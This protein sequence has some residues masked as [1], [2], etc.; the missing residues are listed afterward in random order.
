MKCLACAHHIFSWAGSELV[1]L[2]LVEGL[3]ARGHDV[4]LFCS[5]LDIS[6][7][8]DT[9]GPEVT[10]LFDPAHVDLSQ[11][12]LVF[13]SH[14][15]P[16]RFL[17]FQSDDVL[18]GSARP[19]VVYNHMSPS[20]LFERPGPVS[21]E[22][23]ADLILC[24]S[25]ETKD[26]LS[27]LSPRMAEAEI[28]PN[29]APPG[30]ERAR[31]QQLKSR[32]E[33]LLCVSNHLPEEVEK[34]LHLLRDQGV[35]I[36]K[37]G[38]PNNPKRLTPEILTEHDAVLTIGKT[39]QYA[40]RARVP[41]FC[42]DRY[43]GPGWLTAEN[44]D[45]AA[46]Y[47]FSGRS[48]SLSRLPDALAQKIIQGFADA[49]LF[50][51]KMD[52]TRLS[53]YRLEDHLTR[54]ESA[55]SKHKTQSRKIPKEQMRRLRSEL[56]REYD[57][58]RLVDQEYASAQLKERQ[59]TGVSE[60]ICAKGDDPITISRLHSKEN[61]T[62]CIVATFAYR[63]DAHLVPAMLEN[64]APAVDA[65]I[66]W[67]DRKTAATFSGDAKRQSA[68]FEA[69]KSIGA[70]WILAIDPDERY[71]DALAQKIKGFVTQEPAC[72]IFQCREMFTPTKFRSDGLWGNKK[73]VR[74]FPC[75]PGMEP[76]DE[77]L[78]GNW[79]RNDL[80]LPLR[81]TQL[82]FYH[83]RMATPERRQFR[84]DTYAIADPDRA[85]QGVGYDYLSDDRGSVLTDI[86][87]GHGFSPEYVEDGG[88][89]AAPLPSQ[90][91]I[92]PDPL[93]ARLK[94]LT[95]AKSRGG[96]ASGFF[97]AKDMFDAVPDDA[98]LGFMAVRLA[99]AAGLTAEAQDILARISRAPDM[100]Q[101][102][103]HLRE[104]LASLSVSKEKQDFTDKGATWRRWVS[105]AR[106][107][108]GSKIPKSDMVAVV[109]GLRAPAHLNAAVASLR[110]QD[111][112]LEIVV[113][114]S[115]GG[116][117]KEVLKEQLDYIRL[118][119]VA[120]RLLPGGARNVGI[121]AS[122]APFVSFLA[123]DCLASADWAKGRLERHRAGVQ[124]VASAVSPTAPKN[125]ASMVAHAQLHWPRWPDV[126]AENATL[127]GVSYARNLFADH[128]YF[129]TGVLIGEDTQI[130]RKIQT[131]VGIAW[132]PDV[133]ITHR[134]PTS[135]RALWKDM[136]RR[137]Y[138]RAFSP[139]FS[140]YAPGPDFDRFL[141]SWIRSKTNKAH[142]ALLKHQGLS[143][144]LL[145]RL[146]LALRIAAR[147]ERSGVKRG[148]KDVFRAQALTRK[149]NAVSPDYSRDVEAM[150]REAV[151][152]IP[153][154]AS[155]QAALAGHLLQS[156][157][158]QHVDEI[159]AISLSLVSLGQNDKTDLVVLCDALQKAG[160]AVEAHGILRRACLFSPEC[161]VLWL[162][163]GKAALLVGD[164]CDAY[165]SL[166]MQIFLAPA[167]P[168]AHAAMAE[169][170]AR[171]GENALA[172]RRQDM[173]NLL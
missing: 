134:Y 25:Q 118:I 93:P 35:K 71:E 47:N 6:F 38:R 135:I 122:S 117:P 101:C 51:Q 77:D 28:W 61:G 121:D 78:H 156:D 63:Y 171:R 127:Y 14:Q 91:E 85:Q 20:N 104:G 59:I 139:P 32:L 79:T 133:E 29:P 87:D 54:L 16:A 113:V 106:I 83:L 120:E 49:D 58:Y 136:A 115:G 97:A 169:F 57:T 81:D 1:T 165:E 151:A 110:A 107:H 66:A 75:L 2:E 116:A 150:L 50:A 109:L 94:W 103:R 168:N 105:D 166:H 111:E 164:E 23:F 173:A 88:L 37:I 82:S 153:S 15:T 8:R 96:Q 22:F 157:L 43:T 21:E 69:A 68:L 10:L 80:K 170:Y 144:S 31:S 24:N 108:E 163:R 100:P 154:D 52:E 130:N 140:T 3:K 90:K 141:E 76:D 145:K 18:F 56:A 42:Y 86:P 159:V 124:A 155:H 129:P 125:L 137:G 67:D 148:A 11:Y 158:E 162:H 44:F 160:Y 41:V 74:L 48:H 126:P 112:P 12:D 26:A 138:N 33:R 99:L 73:R 34:T 132:A 53:P 7:V 92:R 17:T 39:V 142:L 128:G 147:A 13:A 46:K 62:P 95:H 172:A 9:L 30:F 123:S 167:D 19:F 114:N 149:A 40:L 152:L 146:L 64:I 4:T 89:W 45:L 60:V 55:V 131:S 72:W 102:H 143:T 84:R 119:D 65:W 27:E 5:F 70:D 161:L 36:T 98:D